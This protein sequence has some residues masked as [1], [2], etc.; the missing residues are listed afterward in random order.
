MNSVFVNVKFVEIH[1]ENITFN[2]YLIAF[3]ISIAIIVLIEREKYFIRNL[4]DLK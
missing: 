3:S 4:L 1:C 2:W